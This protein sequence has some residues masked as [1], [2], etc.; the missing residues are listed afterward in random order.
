MPIYSCFYSYRQSVLSSLLPLSCLC[1]S[2]THI[3]DKPRRSESVNG[4]CERAEG[5]LGRL[6]CA[7]CSVGDPL[8]RHSGPGLFLVSLECDFPPHSPF[9]LLITF[10]QQHRNSAEDPAQSCVVF[11]FPESYNFLFNGVQRDL[12]WNSIADHLLE[13]CSSFF[14]GTCCA[15]RPGLAAGTT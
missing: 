14:S 7:V 5:T 9:G 4:V 12:R 10:Q 3:W 2:C 11:G 13:S 6:R 15:A 1:C 8:H